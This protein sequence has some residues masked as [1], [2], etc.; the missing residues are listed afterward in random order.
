M[1]PL[2]EE[3]ARGEGAPVRWPPFVAP[4]LGV[5]GLT[6]PTFL[7]GL[8]ADLPADRADPSVGEPGRVLDSCVE[9]QVHGVV[10]VRDDVEVLVA[11]PSFRGTP[12]GEVLSALSSAY[13]IDVRWHRGFQLTADE[14]PADFRGPAVRELAFRIARTGLINAAVLGSAALRLLDQADGHAEADVLQLIKQ[15]WHVLVHY[16]SQ[17]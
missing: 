1:A 11:D 13:G 7:Q 3:I 2:L 8:V 16:G 17:A 4:T 9:A 10:L 12:T 15:L 5:S 6:V 14:V